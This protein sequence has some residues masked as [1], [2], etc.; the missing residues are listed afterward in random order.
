MLKQQLVLCQAV[1]G[2]MLCFL[3]RLL[4]L[5]QD[6]DVKVRRYAAQ[7]LQTVTPAAVSSKL[8]RIYTSSQLLGEGGVCQ[9]VQV[10]LDRDVPHLFY[11]T[12]IANMP[13]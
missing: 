6:F 9:S 5:W 4:T 11:R 2:I 10:R 13:M 12:N 7:A 8:P 1:F 3:L